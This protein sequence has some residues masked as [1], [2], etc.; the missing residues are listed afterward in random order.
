MDRMNTTNGHHLELLFGYHY[1]LSP[2]L[3][4]ME[5]AA[6][7]FFLCYWWVKDCFSMHLCTTLRV[8]LLSQP[9]YTNMSQNIDTDRKRRTQVLYVL[10][11][12]RATV[13]AIAHRVSLYRLWYHC[14]RL[15]IK[16]SKLPACTISHIRVNRS[17]LS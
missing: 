4:R 14:I 11:N 5:T 6:R 12:H 13:I 3:K 1:G 8:W 15:S 16:Q 17:L 2:L 7:A 10:Y 9:S